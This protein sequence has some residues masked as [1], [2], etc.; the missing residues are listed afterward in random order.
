MTARQRELLLTVVAALWGLAIGLAL[1]PVW[2]RPAPPGQLPGFATLHNLDAHAPLRFFLGL[3]VLP[4]VVPLV[5][6]PVFRR[7][8]EAEPWARHAVIGAMLFGVWI[9]ASTRAILWTVIPTAIAIAVFF[10]LRHVAMQFTRHDLILFPAF[11]TTF[12]AMIDLGF[13]GMERVVTYAL[14]I[15]M[16]VRLGVGALSVVRFPLSVA[17]RDGTDNGQRTTDNAPLAPAFAFLAAAP[18]GLLLQTSLFTRHVRHLGWPTLIAVIVTPF[19]L[20]FALRNARGAM[21]LLTFVTYPIVAWSYADATSLSTAEGRGR[22]NFFEDGHALLPASEYMRGERAYRDILPGHGLIEDGLLDYLSM[23]VSDD[24]AGKALR[25]R[26]LAGQFNAVA[27]YA[28]G[29]ALTGV[30]ELGIMAIFFGWMTDTATPVFRVLPALVALA[31]LLAAIRRRKPRLFV[32][33]GIASVICGLTSLDFAAYTFVTLVVAAVRMR[34]LRQLLIG[35]CA[36]AVPLFAG[37]AVLGILDDFVVGTF[38]EVLSLGPVYSLTMFV[39]PAPFSARPGFPDV[40]P[41]V[42][43][44]QA[45]REMIWFAAVLFL[46]SFITRRARRRFEP[47][48]MLTLWIALSGVSYVERHHLYFEF[49]IGSALMAVLWMLVRRRS[50]LAPVL[51]IALAAMAMPTAHLSVVAYIRNVRGPIDNNYIAMD[52]LPRARGALFQTA[53]VAMV[54]TVKNYVDTRLAPH[55]TFF[56]FTNRGLLYFLLNRD[57]PIRQYEVAFYEPEERQRAVI[58]ALERQPHVRAALV[59]PKENDRTR[60]DGVPNQMRAPLVWQWLE[61]NFTP[62]V[63][64]GEVVIW[65]RK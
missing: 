20:R 23:S 5:L 45:V 15:V 52:D 22:I 60:V 51:A 24:T 48:L 56:D 47:L 46:G 19:V 18:L 36:A 28:L 40:L 61:Q 31:F 26:K 4:I 53:D 42:F 7:L 49:V 58:A 27:I 41:A 50:V 8:A 6:R 33:A 21:L 62:E 16:A 39:V 34:A 54:S 65:R 37:F 55:E 11:M 43:Q 25:G 63:Q 10:A 57:C 38:R 64:E 30:P 32:Y 29:A 44:L 35:C 1:S 14:A 13:G 3:L 17:D 2:Q 59:P 12:M 9:A